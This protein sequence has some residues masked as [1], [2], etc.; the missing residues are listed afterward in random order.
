MN[1]DVQ[2]NTVHHSTVQC[3]TV[4]YSARL[5]VLP[6]LQSASPACMSARVLGPMS[7]PIQPAGI[8]LTFTICVIRIR[9]KKRVRVKGEA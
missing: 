4:Q 7:S 9:E 6:V 5:S 1:T 8:E 2:Y 3:R